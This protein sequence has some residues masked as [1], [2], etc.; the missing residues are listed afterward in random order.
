MPDPNRSEHPDDELVGFYADPVD[1][2]GNVIAT[3]R[4]EIT[5]VSGMGPIRMVKIPASE[6]D[7][8]PDAPT[9]K[10]GGD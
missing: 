10:I 8:P 9:F 5:H 3:A 2:D 1:E 4:F 6:M 7:M